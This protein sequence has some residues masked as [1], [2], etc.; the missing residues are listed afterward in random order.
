LTR[1]LE[2]RPDQ[3][4]AKSSE[5]KEEERAPIESE[6]SNKEV[7][8]K[9]GGKLKNG[10]SPS[11]MTVEQIQDLIANAVKIQL[12]EGARKT[13]LHNKLYTKRIDALNMPRGY[14]PPK[15]Q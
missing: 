14:Q 9:K 2:K 8:L 11:L 12:G 1:K 10:G 6:T 7:H 5:S 15:F 13:H 4:L 3:S